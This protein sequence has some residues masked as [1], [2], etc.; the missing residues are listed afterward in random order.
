MTYQ[1]LTKKKHEI[2]IIRR[3]A[4]RATSTK[5]RT[6]KISSLPDMDVTFE[7]AVNNSLKNLDGASL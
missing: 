6:D 4:I 5:V 2:I 3:L 7:K 1:K